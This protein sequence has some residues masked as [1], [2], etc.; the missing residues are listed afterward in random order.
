MKCHQLRDDI[1]KANLYMEYA[2]KI[3]EYKRKQSD[4][5]GFKGHGI[6]CARDSL[7]RFL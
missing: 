2:K 1:Q 4:M 6:A 3:K 5:T 7:N